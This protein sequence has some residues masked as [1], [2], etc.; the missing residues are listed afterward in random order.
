MYNPKASPD[1]FYYND[2]VDEA[3]LRECTVLVSLRKADKP[4][5]RPGWHS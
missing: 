4:S 3:Y 1:D 2:N 5:H